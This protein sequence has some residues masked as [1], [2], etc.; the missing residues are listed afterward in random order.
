MEI[1]TLQEIKWETNI[2]D[3]ASD[4]KLTFLG[5]QAEGLALNRTGDASYAAL[6]ARLM[7]QAG[8]TELEESYV[9]PLKAAVLWMVKARLKGE[10][11]TFVNGFGAQLLVPYTTNPVSAGTTE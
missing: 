2:T 9:A 10:A 7:A 1:V 4:A 6:Q 8:V 11:V 3:S 5:N